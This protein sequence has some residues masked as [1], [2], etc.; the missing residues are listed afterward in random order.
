MSSQAF[1]ESFVKRMKDIDK[2]FRQMA[3]FDLEQMLIKETIT[4]TDNEQTI[5]LNA[6]YQCFSEKE[7]HSEVHSNAVRLL[8]CLIKKLSEMNQE[9]LVKLAI[10]ILNIK[11]YVLLYHMKIKIVKM[12]KLIKMVKMIKMVKILRMLISNKNHMQN[13]IFFF[14]IL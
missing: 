2:D 13:H 8:G 9:L 1:W 6:V 11:I 12:A 14:I 7:K 5:V 10:G 3:L 4:L